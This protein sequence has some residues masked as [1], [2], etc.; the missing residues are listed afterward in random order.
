MFCTLF[1][2]NT[3]LENTYN[4]STSNSKC[5]ANIG[6]VVLS[7][8]AVRV[9]KGYYSAVNILSTSITYEQ[10]MLSYFVY[11][12]V[13]IFISLISYLSHICGE[14]RSD[15]NRLHALN[16]QGLAYDELGC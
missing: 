1:V 9:C 6:T 2:C 15:E 8:A 4:S 14:V 10:S 7:S 16:W 13:Y 11:F 3:K 5:D 12:E